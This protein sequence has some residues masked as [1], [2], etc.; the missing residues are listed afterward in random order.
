MIYVACLVLTIYGAFVSRF[1]GGGFKGG[2]PKGIKNTLWSLPFTGFVSYCFV[3]GGFEWYWTAIAGVLCFV[4]CYLGKT[5]GHGQWFLSRAVRAI[6]PEKLDFIV[7]LFWGQDPRT[8]GKY[9]KYFDRPTSV[10]PKAQLQTDMNRYGMIKLYWRNVTGMSVVG[11][12]AVFGAVV[13]GAFVSPILSLV[14]AIGGIMK[15]ASYMIGYA[16][17]GERGGDLSGDFDEA[18]EI[19]ELLT[20]FFAYAGLAVALYLKVSGHV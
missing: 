8:F 20:G 5:T 13:A 6:S 12:A 14:L 11:L 16:I 4:L 17:L 2:V 19:G 18:T 3:T 10:Q 15:G 9:E 7:R 1:H